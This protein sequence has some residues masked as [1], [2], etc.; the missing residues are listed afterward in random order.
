VKLC[1]SGLGGAEEAL[2]LSEAGVQAVLVDPKDLPRALSFPH[3]VLDSGAYR[4]WKRGGAVDVD[5][6]LELVESLGNRIDFAVAPDVIGDP[7]ATRRNWLRVR[8]CPKIVPVW[9]WGAPREHLEEY[10]AERELV[11]VGGLVPFMRVKDERMLA[12]LEALCCEFPGRLHIL[13]INW[14]KA[15]E[16]LRGLAASGDTGKWLDGGRYGHVIF[17]HART[18]R[19]HQAPARALGLGHLGRRERNVLCARNLAEFCRV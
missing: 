17:V 3:V 18:G 12:E 13:G 14:L 9:Q 7:E 1:F 8:R 10:L 6:Y 19:L 4:V 16:R 15:I 5:G 11:C 2:A